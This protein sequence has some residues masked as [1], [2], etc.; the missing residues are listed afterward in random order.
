MRAKFSESLCEVLIVLTAFA[1]LLL[2]LQTRKGRLVVVC[3]V[4]QRCNFI[5]SQLNKKAYRRRN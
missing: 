1:S 5:V 2:D 3:C 4:S